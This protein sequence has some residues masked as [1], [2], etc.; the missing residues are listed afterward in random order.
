MKLE[1]WALIA[2]VI[3][4]VAILVTLVI[5]VIDVRFN[6]RLL[7]RQLFLDRVDRL[8]FGASN[9]MLEIYEKMRAVEADSD[10]AHIQEFMSRYDFTYLEA[11]RWSSYA[12]RTWKTYEADYFLDDTG[13]SGL[14]ENIRGSLR[15]PGLALYLELRPNLFDYRFVE[16]VEELK[17]AGD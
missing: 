15:D 13:F 4:A 6:S 2:E 3:S 1:K 17:S 7:E 8:Y 10:S 16:F 12:W 14:E 11:Q 9:E 5:L